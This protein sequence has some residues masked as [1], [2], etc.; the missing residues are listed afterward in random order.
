MIQVF[1]ERDQSGQISVIRKFRITENY[2]V[3]LN[4]V[5]RNPTVKN[6]LIVARDDDT[7]SIE[8]NLVIK[9]LLITARQGHQHGF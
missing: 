4:N 1:L 8:Q 2:T 9:K 7:Q 6:F 5:V 3:S